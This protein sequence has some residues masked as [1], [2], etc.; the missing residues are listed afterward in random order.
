MRH[1]RSGFDLA[2]RLTNA[3]NQGIANRQLRGLRL[4]AENRSTADLFEPDPIGL[5]AY[6]TT[7]LVG[8]M[9]LVFPLALLTLGL[10]Y[11]GDK[12]DGARGNHI[13]LGLGFMPIGI[14]FVGGV[15]AAWRRRFAKAAKKRYEA[16]NYTIDM[17]CRGLM[18]IAQLNDA[19]IV[20]QTVAGLVLAVLI[21][22]S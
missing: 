1:W 12:I 18:R 9:T 17:R 7:L 4:G 14:C 10:A 22:R 20:L 6:L 11:L 21:A 16:A 15:D 3:I 8:W 2:G 5:Y 13:A 19:T